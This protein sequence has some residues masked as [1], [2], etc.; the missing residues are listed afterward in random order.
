MSGKHVLPALLA[1]LGLTAALRADAAGPAPGEVKAAVVKSIGL[2]QK[3]GTEYL[4]H[5]DCFS[6]HNQGVPIVALTTAMA[7]GFE[8]DGVAVQEQV[9][10]TADFL[11]RNRENYRKGRGQGGQVDTA[12][13]ALLTLEAGGWK[14]D[15]TTSAVVEYLLQRD[16]DQGHWKAVSK[17]PPSEVSP[18]TATYVALRGLQVF[19]TEEQKERIAARTEQARRWLVDAIAKDTEDR[20]FRLWGLKRAEAE[21]KDV[22]AAVRELVKK[23]REDGGWSQTDEMESDAYATGTVL[24]ALHQAGGLSTDDPV[25]RRGLKFLIGSQREDGSWLVRSRSRPFQIYFESGFPHG[26]DQ[27]IS[28][29]A[30]GWATTALALSCPK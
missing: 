19:G 9:Q 30:S 26:K 10:F 2:L 15:A 27:F 8:V 7:R 25:Y 5:R 11:E 16:R 14:P 17:R 21:A 18:F 6:C 29:S 20:V 1:L 4:R 22:Q 12:G 13:Y 24:V 23:Q 3:S 28:C